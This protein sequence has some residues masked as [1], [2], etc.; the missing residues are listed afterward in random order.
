MKKYVMANW[1]NS[2][3]VRESEEAIRKLTEGS[4]D[5]REFLDKVEIVFAPSDLA[6]APLSRLCRK[7]GFGLSSQDTF[8]KEAYGR[9]CAAQL[10]ELCD[11]VVVGH[12]AAR[13]AHG[14]TDGLIHQKITAVLESGMKPVLCIGE[15]A[16][17]KEQGLTG[18]IL[19]GQIRLAL[20]DMDDIRGITILYEPVWAM[21]TGTS[22]PAGETEAVF[23]EIRRAL[24]GL[25]GK[26]AEK[27]KIIYAG[28]IKP[29]NAGDYVSQPGIDGLAVGA[30]SLE[31]ESFYEVI[32]AV[33][34]KIE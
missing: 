26:E 11:Y 10:A 6:L 23:S 5:L 31:P 20:S 22:L 27:T 12:S 2:K 19:E 4:L 18:R 28:S 29:S 15:N 17:Q 24:K 33:Y 30:A 25:W 9:T 16:V 13:K 32:R 14:D 1:K 7:A 21:G 34:E 3:T 8:Y